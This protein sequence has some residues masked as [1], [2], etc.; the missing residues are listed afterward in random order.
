[1][2][3]IS[4]TIPTHNRAHLISRAINSVKKQTFENWQLII[5]DDGSTDNT[6]DVILPF[7]E[8]ERINYLKKENSGAAHSRNVGV[9]YS[10]GDFITFLDSDD[11]AK[12]DWLDKIYNEITSKMASVICCGCETIDENGDLIKINLPSK[13]KIFPDTIYKM[14]N[15][16]V[17]TLTKTIFNEIGGFDNCLKSGQH[18]ELSFR[19]I[20]YLKENKIE[21]HN[22]QESL[23]KIHIHKG[24]R[25]RG[26]PE[27]KF[28][29]T[30]YCLKKHSSF[31]ENRN[32][33]RADYEGTVGM[34]AYL[35]NRK[36]E[37]IKYFTKSFLSK[38]SIKRLVRIPVYF[39]KNIIKN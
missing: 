16:G 17:F 4:I 6:E 7:L 19:L 3:K 22:L 30:T 13:T 20:P 39:L 1:M 38:P 2:S 12:P 15:G 34:N 37:S 10:T 18:T 11:E 23:I 31:F 33:L 36:L 25:I 9:E 8:D 5:V 21:I 29:G 32:L 24:E 14:T 28:Q 35:T 26:N 27:M